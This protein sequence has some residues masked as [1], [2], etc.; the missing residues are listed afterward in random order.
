MWK[1]TGSIIGS[2]HSVNIVYDYGTVAIYSLLVHTPAG[3]WLFEYTVA[4]HLFLREASQ[5]CVR[6]AVRVYIA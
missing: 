6:D 2:K 5:V 4:A 1:K 3:L